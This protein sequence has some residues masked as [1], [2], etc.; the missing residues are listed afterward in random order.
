MQSQT[1]FDDK[2]LNEF[3]IKA[4]G[5]VGSTYS[6]MLVIIGE[7]LGLYKAMAEIGSTTSAELADK[8]D[9]SERYVREWLANQA[10]G[11]YV[12]YNTTDD[13]YSQPPEQT[14]VLADENSPVYIHG[15]Y[16]VIRSIF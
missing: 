5:D 4:A 11:G 6:A 15:A 13:T 2:K 1:A 8:T 16:H 12:I 14:L 9:T 3:M 7:R 10:A